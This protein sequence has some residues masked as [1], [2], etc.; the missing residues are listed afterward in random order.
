LS[1]KNKGKSTLSSRGFSERKELTSGGLELRLTS[2]EWR[3]HRSARGGSGRGK[4]K[5]SL[6]HGAPFIGGGGRGLG[7]GPW[8]G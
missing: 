2:V 3:R 1:C 5:A 8:R 7:E 4:K 6:V